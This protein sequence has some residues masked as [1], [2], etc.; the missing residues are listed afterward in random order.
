MNFIDE[1][2]GGFLECFIKKRKFGKYLEQTGDV[3]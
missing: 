3:S 2:G 1:V